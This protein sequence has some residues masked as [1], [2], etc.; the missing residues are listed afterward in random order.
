MRGTVSRKEEKKGKETGRKQGGGENIV[1]QGE[2]EREAE[3]RRCRE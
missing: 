1:R 3:R 2:G